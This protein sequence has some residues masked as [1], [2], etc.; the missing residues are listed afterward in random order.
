MFEMRAH[1]YKSLRLEAKSHGKSSWIEIFIDGQ[2]AGCI[3]LHSEKDLRNAIA[4]TDA[5]NFLMEEMAAVRFIDIVEK[6]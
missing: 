3:F 6:A 5:W 1:A 4:A 2:T